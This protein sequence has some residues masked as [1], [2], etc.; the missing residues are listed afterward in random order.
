MQKLTV[1]LGAVCL[2]LGTSLQAQHETL[3]NQARVVGAFGGPITEYGL[4]NDL[5][6]SVGGGGGL[7][8]NSFFIGGYGLAAADF[9]RLY[10]DGELEVL[11]V[12][13][14]GI[15]L[16]GTYCTW[17]VVAVFAGAQ[18]ISTWMIIPPT[19]I[20]IRFLS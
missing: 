5:N 11:D 6:T 1:L 7:I 9:D 17:T 13:H 10:E 19:A 16:G 14:G 2:F 4:S 12:G 18:L 3:F 15:W 8:I 20:W